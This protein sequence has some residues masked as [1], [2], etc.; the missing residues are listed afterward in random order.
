MAWLHYD[1]AFRM[2]SAIDPNMHQDEPQPGLWLQ[3]MTPARPNTGDQFNSGHLNKKAAP[4][5][6][7]CFAAGQAFQPHMFCWE[8][9]SKGFCTKTLCYFK[10]ECSTC[11]GHHPKATCFR[12]GVQK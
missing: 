8:Y 11:G 4:G 5:Q 7:P 1:E 6:N 12:A 10:H 9:N 3:H 2:G